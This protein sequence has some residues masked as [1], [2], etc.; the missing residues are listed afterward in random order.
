MKK[1]ISFFIL[2]LVTLSMQG[3]AWLW[4][5]VS[6]G[7]MNGK[8]DE[9]GMNYEDTGVVADPYFLYEHRGQLNE[10]LIYPNQKCR[11]AYREQTLLQGD[12]Q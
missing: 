4:E 8:A 10:A 6:I 7:K 9:M 11:K 1:I 12:S 3:C 2:L 5:K